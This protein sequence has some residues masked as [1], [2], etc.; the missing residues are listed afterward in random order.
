MASETYE[1]LKKIAQGEEISRW[2]YP[3]KL[4]SY[5]DYRSK[6]PKITI[7]FDDDDDFLDIFD[8]DRDSDDRYAWAKFMGNYYSDDYD[9]YR[10]EDDWREGYIIQDFNQT[11]I[12]KLETILRLT[13]PTLK[14]GD[15]NR[16]EVAK[17][18]DK[19]FSSQIDELVYDYGLAHSECVTRAVKETI[20]KDVK[21]PFYKFGIIE[22]TTAYKFQ[23]SVK[24][25][26]KLYNLLEAENEDLK[27]LLKLIYEKY[28][29]KSVGGWNELEYN[30]WCDDYDKES[31]QENIGKVLDS[32][33]ESVEDD[34]SDEIVDF[35]EYNKLYAMV[36]KLGGFNKLIKFPEKNIEVV[37]EDININTGKLIFKVWKN[38]KVER[39]S[40]DNIDDLNLTLYHPELFE[41]VRRILKK[42]L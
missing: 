6:I 20:L 29:D 7:T 5:V 30:A 42:L 3:D 22:M 23:T 27:G 36:L 25:L 16:S 14:L 15:D 4:I 8:I 17:F 12:E 28:G 24:I 9:R 41:S 19:M 39:R 1:F 33:I 26:L 2:E 37:F 35:D 40:V 18:I 13:N 21:N 11:N 10:Y 34:L 38:S 32:I 31:E